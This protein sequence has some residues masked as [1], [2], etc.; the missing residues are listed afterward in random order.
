[1]SEVSG[2]C[3]HAPLQPRPPLPPL[4]W[5][6]DDGGGRL[7]LEVEEFGDPRPDEGAGQLRAPEPPKRRSRERGGL[8]EGR[9]SHGSDIAYGIDVPD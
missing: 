9:V 7:Q 2:W 6:V 8:T 4:G 3:P 1:V 5:G